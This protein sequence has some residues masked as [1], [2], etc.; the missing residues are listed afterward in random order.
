M[1][2]QSKKVKNGFIIELVIAV[3]IF[4]T[5]G[6]LISLS[7]YTADYSKCIFWSIILLIDTCTAFIRLKR[8]EIT[9]ITY[10]K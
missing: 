10:N 6:S 8:I 1:D 9:D 3:I 7:I 5:L 4:M 2:K